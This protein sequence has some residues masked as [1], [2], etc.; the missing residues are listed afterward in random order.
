[1]KI[2]AVTFDLWETLLCERDG[3]NAKRMQT[4]SRKLFEALNVL[5]LKV[6]PE[7]VDA[8]LKHTVDSLLLEWHEERDISH[9]DQLTLF[10]KYATDGKVVFRKELFSTLSAAY[11]S[12]L[13]EVP[14]YLNS[15]A[16]HVLRKLDLDKKKVGLICN[17]GLTP[18]IAL[19]MFL[20]QNSVL[21]FF[22][23]MLFSDEVR[24]RKPDPRI[25]RLASKNLQVEPCEIVHVGDSVK[26]DIGGAK[27]AGLWAI[28]LVSNSGVDRIAE[29]DPNSLLSL[30]RKMGKS[31]VKAE[32][33]RI[34]DSLGKVLE[35]IPELERL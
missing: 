22:D 13:F 24:M 28:L 35:A 5:N 31:G 9:E 18:G 33:D 4:R 30:A 2:R 25:F 34:V 29:N 6:T 26:S 14:P 16:P 10:F 1:M 12:P 21:D 7:K 32:P 27:A 11:V 17:T 3:A 8:A 19:R 20:D 23:V 15:D